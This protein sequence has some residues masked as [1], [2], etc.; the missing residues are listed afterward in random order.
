MLQIPNGIAAAAFALGFVY[1]AT[2]TKK[3]TF[4]AVASSVV[5]LLGCVLMAVIPGTPKLAGFY[6][7]WAMTGVGALIQTLVSN[8]VSG[9]T[10]RVFYNSMGMVA[11]TIGNFLGP[12]MM[13]GNQAPTYTGAM[14]GFSISNVGIIS[15][16]FAVYFIL[17]RDNKRRLEHATETETDVYLDLT[18]K[19]DKNFVYKL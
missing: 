13:S 14:I 19:T 16:L 4:T 2:R 11:M 18:D 15:C 12:L 5:S 8:N 3:I 6:L 1:I 9:Y 7:T 17:K 10:K